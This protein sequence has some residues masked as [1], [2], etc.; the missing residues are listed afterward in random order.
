MYFIATLFGDN[1]LALGQSYSFPSASTVYK[2][3]VMLNQTI[4]KDNKYE[5]LWSWGM[6]WNICSLF[7]CLRPWDYFCLSPEIGTHY[8]S[9]FYRIKS[10]DNT[11]QMFQSP[12]S[13]MLISSNTGN[14]SKQMCLEKSMTI[15]QNQR[16]P[17]RCFGDKTRY[18][19]ARHDVDVLCG[20]ANKHINVCC[21]W[22][23][24]FFLL[25][26]FSHGHVTPHR[27]HISYKFKS[28]YVLV[29]STKIE[30]QQGASGRL[31]CG[32]SFM[33]MENV[34]FYHLMPWGQQCPEHRRAWCTTWRYPVSLPYQLVVY[35]Y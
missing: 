20:V 35:I 4:P 14:M 1:N 9:Y 19:S 31:T 5:Y 2:T 21:R 13:H 32:N 29:K 6:F 30:S 11:M 23:W 12:I 22:W 3:L 17:Q 16:R 18:D 7:R 34:C 24:C 10:W 15:A 25:I 27:W 26:A 33:S 8:L 28:T